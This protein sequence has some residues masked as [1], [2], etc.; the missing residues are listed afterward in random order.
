[1]AL[2]WKGSRARAVAHTPPA[3]TG[4]SLWSHQWL[5]DATREASL[6][7]P[8]SEAPRIHPGGSD[9][10]EGAGGALQ[11]LD[12]YGAAT[13]LSDPTGKRCHGDEARDAL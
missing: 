13:A 6:P 11:V 7:L 3:G 9:S 4:S 2:F 10:P 1:M 5:Q 8:P 12:R